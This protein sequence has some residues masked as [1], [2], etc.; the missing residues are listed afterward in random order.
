MVKR[1]KIKLVEQN[2]SYM[3]TTQSLWV[4]ADDQID[5]YL[6]NH[7]YKLKDKEIAFVDELNSKGLIEKNLT[8][9]FFK[10]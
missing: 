10:W 6:K 8:L 3:N 1:Y 7:N 4:L 2:P 5:Q 9:Y